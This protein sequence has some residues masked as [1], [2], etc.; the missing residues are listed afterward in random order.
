MRI[1]GEVDTQRQAFVFYSFLLEQ[2]IHSSYEPDEN[3]K[4]RIWIYEEEKLELAKQL[5]QEYK[6]NP[7]DPR[8]VDIEFP[9][10]PPQAPD[11][12]AE[13][14]E[15]KEPDMHKRVKKKAY[16]L[17]SA[18]L[19]ICIFLFGWTFIQE[20]SLANKK[21][22]V[23]IRYGMTS[24]SRNLMFDYPEANLQ[25]DHFLE[26]HSLKGYKEE[27]E[28]PDDL[29]NQ[30]QHAKGVPTWQGIVPIIIDWIKGKPYQEALHAPKFQ[31]IRE[32][33]YWRLITPVFMHGGL[34]HI[35]FNMAWVWI[36]VPPLE[37][38]LPIWKVLLL[39]LLIGL[40]SN[41]A[42]YIMTGPY[43]VGFSGIIVGIIGFI[44]MRQKVAPWEGYSLS[45]T[46]LSFVLMFILAMFGLGVISFILEATS[47]ISSGFNI[48][49][50]AHIVGGLV[51]ILLG[52]TP[53]FARGIQHDRS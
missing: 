2:G 45:P 24:L 3:G 50:T 5:L 53:L 28:L 10:A 46:T 6:D 15:S 51:G 37:D 41:L 16:P 36:L 38:K 49:N 31:K 26:E 4:H 39:M 32:G 9:I 12:I 52:I 17:T 43:F 30:L 42:Q 1:I 7:R 44:W 25:I 35:L 13:K 14:R 8:F 22:D 20:I 34:L 23:A 27:S 47:V 40:I 29:K 11:R 21:G 33:E 19:L 48:A 18:I